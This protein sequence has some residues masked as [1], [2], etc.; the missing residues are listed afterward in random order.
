M[1]LGAQE[2]P[3]AMSMQ[4]ST[5]SPDNRWEFTIV[6]PGELILRIFRWQL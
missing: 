3:N 2:N 4:S 1:T 5:G 6:R